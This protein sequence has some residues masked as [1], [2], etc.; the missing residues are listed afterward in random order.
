M[1]RAAALGWFCALCVRQARQK[2]TY[3]PEGSAFSSV[4]HAWEISLQDCTVCIFACVSGQEEETQIGEETTERQVYC[5]EA[6][7]QASAMLVQE[8]LVSYRM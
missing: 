1:L 2:H 3:A 4:I 6:R 5:L 8:E 7:G